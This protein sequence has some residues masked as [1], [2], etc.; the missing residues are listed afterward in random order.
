MLEALAIDRCLKSNGLDDTAVHQLHFFSD[1]S[2]RGYTAV[3]Y[4]RTVYKLGKISCSFIIGKARLCPKKSTS[5]PRLE[6]TA[7]VLSVQISKMV[8]EELRL[9]ITDVV[10]WYD[11]TSVLQYKDF[12]LS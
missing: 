2:E 8:Q 3:A 1:A 6:L 4:L 12:E 10:F 11:S 9:P 5:I 7:A